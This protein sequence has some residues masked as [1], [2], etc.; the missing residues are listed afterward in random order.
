MQLTFLCAQN[1]GGFGILCAIGA[2]VLSLV[3]CGDVSAQTEKKGNPYSALLHSAAWVNASDG[4]GTAWVVDRERKL[5]VT[6]H[7]VV[8]NTEK[9]RCDEQVFLIFPAYEGG[10]PVAERDYYRQ[11]IAELVAAGRAMPARVLD[12]DRT[13]DLAFLV[14]QELPPDVT[15]V[16]LAPASPDPGDLLHSI[17]NP[18]G[19]DALWLYTQGYVK[20]VSRKEW[21]TQQGKEFARHEARVV[22]TQAPTNHGD[23]GGPVINDKGELVAVTQGGSVSSHLLNVAIDVSEVRKYLAE[24]GWMAAMQTAADY[25]RRAMR[26]YK[27]N[28]VDLALLDLTEAIRLQPDEPL[29]WVNRAK[30]YNSLAITE[31]ILGRFGIS[32]PPNPLEANKYELALADCNTALLRNPQLALAYAQRGEVYSSRGQSPADRQD[33]GTTLFGRARLRGLGASEPFSTKLGAASEKDDAQLALADCEKALSIDRDCGLAYRVLARHF[34][35][36]D[37]ER[38]LAN[39]TEALRVEPQSADLLSSRA[40]EY[41]LVGDIPRAIADLDAAIRIDP[42]NI[43]HYRVRAGYYMDLKDYPK[44]FE[45]LSTAI[46]LCP[47]SPYDWKS[48]AECLLAAGQ[49]DKAIS[50]CTQGLEVIRILDLKYSWLADLLELRGDCYAAKGDSALARADYQ[51]VIKADPFVEEK[52]KRLNSKLERLAQ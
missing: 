11:H 48:R 2:A 1:R 36:R 52:V 15:A 10:K 24:T 25:N 37:K 26:Y 49:F 47:E 38:S 43:V 3:A 20:Q 44:A 27:Q 9:S 34:M 19:S 13:I 7:H 46:S 8:Y 5:L 32:P 41:K 42:K 29:Y 14:V 12:A 6:N 21:R 45:D 50:D 51:A 22:E 16:P 31:T 30:I 18:G 28:S 23:S 33:S 17:G 39:Y 35:T 40:F 4:A